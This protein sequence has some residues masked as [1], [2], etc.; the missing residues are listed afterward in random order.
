MSLAQIHEPKLYFC[1]SVVENYVR[2]FLSST[3]LVFVSTTV[4]PSINLVF[5]CTDKNLKMPL[6]TLLKVSESTDFQI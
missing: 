1:V 3:K 2:T 6:Y 4:Q 5:L